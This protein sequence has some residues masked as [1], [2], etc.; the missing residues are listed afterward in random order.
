MGKLFA[1]IR[2]EYIERVRNKW[3]VIVTVF[4]PVFFAVVMILP[5]Y[6]SVRNIRDAKVADLRVVDATGM[7]LGARVAQR[8]A[9]P[10]R[11]AALPA[12]ADTSLATPG[13]PEAPAAP[14]KLVRVD[15]VSAEGL[16]AAESTL[17]LDVMAKKLSGYLILDSATVRSGRARYAGRNASSVGENEQLENSLRSALLGL[18]LETAGVTASAADSITRL[19]VNLDAER[20]TDTGKGGSGIGGAIFG[21]VIAF[22]LYVAIILYGQQIL[23]GVLEEKT[24]RVAE[25]IL[26]SV[27]PDILLAGKVIGVGAVGLTQFGIWIASGLFFWGERM[28]LVGAIA[29][30][31]AAS[32]GA[33]PAGFAFPTIEPFTIVALLLFFLL[34]YTF[35]AALFAAVGAM[36]GTQEEA[37]QAVQPVMMMLVFSII[38]VQ[39]VMTNPTG[40][41]AEV[42]SLI[43]F[44]APIIM[45]MRMT[46]TPVPVLTVLASLAGVA[47]AALAA[48]WFAARIYR[49]GL[50][51]YG[52]RPSLR[53]LLRWV[54][55]S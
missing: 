33:M 40:R 23:R 47:L 12:V 44:S 51:M 25:V 17:V 54:R 11:G 38:F 4:G 13:A 10:R 7:G 30:P 28:K 8:I 35:Y 15:T 1:V 6:L 14:V 21:F 26:A 27:K 22:T 42:M 46:A 48:I 45:P 3:F 24:T 41:L 31:A 34:G 20:I 29:G 18:R 19:K 32:A 9:E 36:V 55:Q 53:E 39:P 16:A 50:L 37:S 5:A 2:R 43:P 49:V 52:K